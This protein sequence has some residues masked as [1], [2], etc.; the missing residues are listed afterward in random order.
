VNAHRSS[1]FTLGETEDQY[2]P[3]CAKTHAG[4]ASA[5]SMITSNNLPTTALS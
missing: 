3:N 4:L 1:Y 5:A 2:D